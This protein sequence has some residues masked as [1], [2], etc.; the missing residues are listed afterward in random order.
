MDIYYDIH[1]L[2]V[3]EGEGKPFI[4][5]I[6]GHSLGGF[7]NLYVSLNTSLFDS[8]SWIQIACKGLRIG[9]LCNHLDLLI[10]LSSCP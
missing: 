8:N 4:R 10:M 1:A 6:Y 3:E 5:R 9:V 7:T 2:Y